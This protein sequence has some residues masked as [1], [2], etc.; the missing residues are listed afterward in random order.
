[1]DPVQLAMSVLILELALNGF[2]VSL[3]FRY[4]IPIFWAELPVTNVTGNNIAADDLEAA[5]PDS[6]FI[7][8]SFRQLRSN[9]NAFREILWPAFFKVTY[10]PVMHGHLQF[11][12]SRVRVIGYVNWFPLAFI[13]LF[14]PMW[15]DV[16]SGNRTAFQSTMTGFFTLVLG[17]IIGGIY[18]VQVRRYR[19]VARIAADSNGDA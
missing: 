7:P 5:I 11:R 14:V 9:E 15:R 17:G 4:G 8:L 6:R 16:L 12:H 18:A 1:M 2:W 10:T 3:Y 19:D 13:Y